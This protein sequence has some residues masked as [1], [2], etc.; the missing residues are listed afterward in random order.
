VTA[1]TKRHGDDRRVRRVETTLIPRPPAAHSRV[2]VE[3]AVEVV[4]ALHADKIADR[5][6]GLRVAP[7][8]EGTPRRD[9]AGLVVRAAGVAR[10]QFA[11]GVI[12]FVARPIAVIILLIATFR[13][14]LQGLGATGR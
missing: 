3:R 5:R 10:E 9:R 7:A 13:A 11:L 12:V 4:T 1:E 6:C 8:A 2:S 14:W